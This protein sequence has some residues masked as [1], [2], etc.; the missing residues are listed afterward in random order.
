MISVLAGLTRPTG[1]S[2]R[3]LGSDVQRDFAEDR[4]AIEWSKAEGQ[5][6]QVRHFTVLTR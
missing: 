6:G 5:Q 1:G 4:L 3:V 2:V